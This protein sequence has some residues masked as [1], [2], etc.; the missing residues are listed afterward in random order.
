MGIFSKFGKAYRVYRSETYKDTMG[1]VERVAAS[2]LLL[3]DSKPEAEQSE[4][5]ARVSSLAEKLNDTVAEEIPLVG[6]V[7][8][9]TALR[10]LDRVL[11]QNADSLRR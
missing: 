4:I 7:A 10:V 2:T 6:A 9:L 8:L 3:I 5:L 1:A 11:Q